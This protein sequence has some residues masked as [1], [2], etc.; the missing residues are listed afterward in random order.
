MAF[1]KGR[2]ESRGWVWCGTEIHLR[3][4]GASEGVLVRWWCIGEALGFVNHRY[5]RK[6]ESMEVKTSQ[7]PLFERNLGEPCVAVNVAVLAEIIAVLAVLHIARR[8][9]IEPHPLLPSIA[10]AQD[11]NREDKTTIMRDV[12]KIEKCPKKRACPKQRKQFRPYSRCCFPTFILP[13]TKPGLTPLTRSPIEHDGADTSRAWII[14]S[15]W[16]LTALL[17]VMPVEEIARSQRLWARLLW[18]WKGGRRHRTRRL[19]CGWWHGV[20]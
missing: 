10:I 6:D 3:V 2:P 15:S 5:S 17:E 9:S 19:G 12:T 18:I 8:V 20:I 1:G 11:S 13:T 14:C 7:R 16:D 4:G